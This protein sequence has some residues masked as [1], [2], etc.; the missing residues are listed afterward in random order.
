MSGYDDPRFLQQKIEKLEKDLK[1]LKAVSLPFLVHQ[2]GAVPGFM[3]A[4]Q[5]NDVGSKSSMWLNLS[6]SQPGKAPYQAVTDAS[7]V[8]RVE[9]GNLDVNGISPAQLGFR[10]NDAAGAPIFDSLGLIA[11]MTQLANAFAG[12]TFNVTSS[13]PTLITGA[14]IT[15]SLSR[16]ISVLIAYGASMSVPATGDGG[17]DTVDLFIDSVNKS[18][19]GNGPALELQFAVTSNGSATS[20]GVYSLA[21]ASGSHTVE[22]RAAR[23]GTNTPTVLQA[24]VA[25]YNMG[26]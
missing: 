18:A 17:V 13:T 23:N 10:A 21:L 16:Q 4:V 20:S 25:A 7:G 15:F 26:K 5:L 22:L 1:D 11:V 6:G 2:R 8:I 19:A 14:T 9:I 24:G 3:R 12:S